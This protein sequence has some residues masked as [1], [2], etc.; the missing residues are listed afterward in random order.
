MPGSGGT[1]TFKYDPFGRRIQ[2]TGP[3][4]ATGYLHDGINVIE[5]V[6]AGGNAVARYTQG[7]GV[8]HPLAMTRAGVTSFY[9]QDAPRS[10]TSLSDTAGAIT[11]T[12]TYDSYGNLTASSGTTT[13]PF[14]YT[15][16]EFDPETGL[17]YYRARYYDPQIGRFINEDPLGFDGGMDFYAYADNNPVNEIDPLGLQG[18]MGPTKPPMPVP[19]SPGSQWKWVPDPN[20]TRGG[21]YE[22]D[23]WDPGL[24]PKPGV[25]WEHVG[26]GKPGEPGH[27]DLDKGDGTR[28]RYDKR[29][30]PITPGQAHGKECVIVQHNYWWFLWRE[31]YKYSYDLWHDPVH[32]IYHFPE[33]HPLPGFGPPGRPM[34]NAPGNGGPPPMSSCMMTGTCELVP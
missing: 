24:G 22:P 14:R 25:S 4:G 2:K 33:T 23:E 30:N 32:D 11:D 6:D 13:N 15:G 16:R 27:W 31:W 34:N 5:E 10:I 17:Y 28:Q 20:N 7:S 29:G 26:R 9:E 12:Y 8:D 1:V 21:R 3:S 19:G 18:G